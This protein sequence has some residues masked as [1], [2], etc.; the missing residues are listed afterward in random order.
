MRPLFD[1]YV[2]GG[3]GASEPFITAEVCD[4]VRPRT[5]TWTH[6]DWQAWASC[7]SHCRWLVRH[8]VHLSLR[9]TAPARRV[10]LKRILDSEMG[11]LSC[12]VKRPD[13]IGL[14]QGRSRFRV[15]HSSASRSLGEQPSHPCSVTALLSTAVTRSCTVPQTVLFCH[16][17]SLRP[18]LHTEEHALTGHCTSLLMYW[19]GKR[20]PAC[21]A[22]TE[23]VE[24][25]DLGPRQ[26]RHGR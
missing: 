13:I 8:Y 10:P 16:R 12:R 25:V 20:R 19:R 18:E 24:V 21:R 1:L 17:V 5:R 22:E 26:C 11:D 15:N 23:R 2:F 9:P 14:R 7:D 3:Y 4:E 6:G